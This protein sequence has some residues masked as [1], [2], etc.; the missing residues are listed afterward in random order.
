MQVLSWQQC[1]M[2]RLGSVKVFKTLKNQHHPVHISH[3]STTMKKKKKFMK[4]LT[5]DIKIN[6][7]S[8]INESKIL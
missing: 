1:A 8:Q 2:E 3:R 7:H 5:F 4:Y 6:N